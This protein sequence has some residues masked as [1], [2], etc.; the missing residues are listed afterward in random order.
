MP[1]ALR[2]YERTVASLLRLQPT[3]RFRADA[4]ISVFSSQLSKSC[5][6]PGALLHCRSMAHF[7]MFKK[8]D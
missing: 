4:R 1:T 5:K 2:L 7:L 3:P 8:I 6:G